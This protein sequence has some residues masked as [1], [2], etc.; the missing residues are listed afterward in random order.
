MM[1]MKGGGTIKSIGRTTMMLWSVVKNSIKIFIKTKSVQEV[2]NRQFY[3]KNKVIVELGYIDYVVMRD[4]NKYYMSGLTNTAI[5]AQQDYIF[6]DIR[7]EDIVIDIGASVGGFSIPASKKA[8]HVYAVEP[9]T[10]DMLTKN[11][12]LNKSEN[13]DVLDVA[14][15][16]GETTR[17]EWLGKSRTVKTKTL[18]EIK[19]MCG[20]CDFLKID[21]EG[22]EWNI[23]PE[24]LKGIRRIEMEVHKVG[25]PFSM[26]EE[27]L[28]KA[29]FSYEVENQPEGVI[30]LWLIH[31]RSGT[32]KK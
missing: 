8:K 16:D 10:Q 30:G 3:D 28:S 15:G 19:K 22:C 4:G 24:E 1:G 7:K 21:C 12:L 29:G 5:Q 20:G 23:K 9:M 26:M 18:T 32:K 6:D 25:F 11:I 27:R 13:I 17:L 2:I 14:L 31:A